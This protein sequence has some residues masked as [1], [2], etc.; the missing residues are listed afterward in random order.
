[1]FLAAPVMRTVAR[2]LLP[3]TR[4]ATIRARFSSGAVDWGITGDEWHRT[5]RR[6]VAE[7]LE[8]IGTMKAG[9]VLCSSPQISFATASN[10][11]LKSVPGI[12]PTQGEVAPA[13]R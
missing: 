6:R 4:Q 1:V 2:M 11:A 3:S 8:L 12:A 10:A 7:G 9:Q 5:I 13:S